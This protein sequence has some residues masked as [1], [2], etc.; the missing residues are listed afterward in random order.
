MCASCGESTNFT[1]AFIERFE[2]FS[3][4]KIMRYAELCQFLDS[5][6]CSPL[7]VLRIHLK[8]ALGW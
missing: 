5:N 3:W 6:S 7:E 1:V 8:I 2:R 4:L